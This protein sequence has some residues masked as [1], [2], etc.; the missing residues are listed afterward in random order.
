MIGLKESQVL[1]QPGFVFAK[2]VDSTTDRRHMLTKIQVE[3][4]DQGGVDLP[5]PLSQDRFDGR[6]RAEDDAVLDP[7]DAPA[8]IGFD[9]L[10]IE[11]PGRGHPAWLGLRPSVM[12]AFGLSPLAVVG[13]QGGKVLTKPVREKPWGTVRCQPLG[14]LMDQALGHSE[15][16]LPNVN[17]QD[18]LAHGVHRHPDPVGGSRQALDRLALADL[19]ILDRTEQGEEFIHLHLVDVEVVQEVVRE[20]FEVIS[21]LRQPASHRVGIGLKD[22]GRGADAEPFGQCRGGPHQLVRINRL[23]MKQRAMGFQ[24]MP[25]AAEAKQVTPASTLGR[26]VGA[27]I[28]QAHP[29]VVRAGGMGTEV[30][31]GIDLSATASGEGHTEWRGVGYGC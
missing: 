31:A 23:A 28:A 10:R 2:R 9:D 27:D 24:E 8:P 6:W 12:A 5:T 16:A 22:P 1:A 19:A 11:Q 3:A 18:E 26:A 29:T 14:D 20:G 21:G 17:G 25:L 4:L 30:T 15:G 13:H 7:D